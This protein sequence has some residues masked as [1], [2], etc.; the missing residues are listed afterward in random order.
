MTMAISHMSKLKIEIDA[1][2]IAAQFG[3]LKYE[4]SQALNEAV[5]MASVMAYGIANEMAAEKLKSRL[6]PYQE[7]LAYEEISPGMWVV[8]LDE[9]A[10][11]IEDGIEP[12]DQREKLLRTGYKVSKDGTKYRSIPFE[13]S[14]NP[15]QQTDKA[16]QITQMV[17][18]E[19]RARDIPFKKIER[20]ASGSPRIGKIHSFSVKD[21]P[22]PSPKAKFGALMGVNVYQRME[23]KKAV[24]DIMT[25]RTI[26]SKVDDRWMHPG[27]KPEKILDLTFDKIQQVF[28]NEILPEVMRKYSVFER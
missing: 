1:E 25:F 16:R 23:G 4:V 15:S 27:L 22:K 10:F 12:H 13:H 9:S 14:K 8:S 26:T 11:W 6:K 20:D 17:K 24:R 2:E 5:R 28:D 21:S 18:K 7:A 19:L 3:D